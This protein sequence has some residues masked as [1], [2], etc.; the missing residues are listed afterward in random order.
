MFLELFML[1]QP[2]P[3]VPYN[4]S[5]PANP[6]EIKRILEAVLL[7]SQDPLSLSELRK[8]FNEEIN[9][10]IVRK[11]LEELRDEWRNKGIELVHV[12]S[13]WRFHTRPEIQQFLDKLNP[14]RP[15]R[16]SRSV[17]EILAIIAYRQPVTR[18][19]I[20]E[21][22]GVAVSGQSLKALELRG[23]VESIGHRD[24]PGRPTLYATT[25]SFLD[26][27]GLRSIEELPPLEDSGSLFELESNIELSS[28]QE[29]IIT[30]SIE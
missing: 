3:L 19:D 17:L 29:S 22:R 27:L 10:E 18:G 11:L 16:Y 20:E 13:G 24:V 9:L 25:K 2:I 23:W 15:L 6:N 26:D 14:Q 12:A 5:G 7:T 30:E 28:A 1:D 8:I 21:I 4:L